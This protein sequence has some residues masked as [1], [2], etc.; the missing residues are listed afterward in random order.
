MKGGFA[1][2][3]GEGNTLRWQVKLDTPTS[4]VLVIE[5][6]HVAGEEDGPDV[7]AALRR[8]GLRAEVSV[9]GRRIDHLNRH[10]D[11]STWESVWARIPV[12]SEMLNAGTNIVELRQTTDRETGRSGDCEVRGIRLEIPER[13]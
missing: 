12:P 4:A 11:R 6:A 3:K 1:L 2:A 9:N 5:V 13:R 8:G 10:V 7:K